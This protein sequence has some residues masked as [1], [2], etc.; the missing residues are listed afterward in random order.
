M[1]LPDLKEQRALRVAEMR[2]ILSAAETQKRSLTADEQGRFDKLKTE[3]TGL[4][5]D[6]ARAQFL[7]DAERR[8]MGGTD[9]HATE[10]ESRISLTDAIN[11]QVEGRALNGALAEY[12]QE[13]KRIGIVGRGVLVPQ[14]LF[15]KR[16]QTTGNS[17][18]IVPDDFLATEY[19]GLMR[20]SMVIQ[21]LGARVLPNLR[22]DTVIPKALTAHTAQWIG[23]GEALTPAD[24]TFG[25][26]TLTPKHVGALTSVSRQLLQQSNPAVEALIRDDFV[27]VVSLAVDKALIDGD[28]VNEPMGILERTG[29]GHAVQT[30]S[31]STVNWDA[32]L[33]VLEKLALVNASPNAWVTHPSV[34]TVLRG[35]LKDTGLPGYLMENGQL[36][37][38]PVAVTNQISAAA[39]NDG[40]MI[41]GDFSQIVIGQWGSVDILANPYETTAY[42]KGEV[43]IRILS[44]MDMN[45][46]NENAFVLIED[47]TI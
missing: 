18:S 5:A 6:E 28:G 47:V 9:K 44:T 45:V 33:T 21:K 25:S 7:E 16:V 10:L 24:A 20:N 30:G 26:I 29:V 43:L 36:A 35:T 12:Q 8:A 14:S 40:R 31:L 1:K 13:Q 42:T 34:A 15:E 11:A 27:Q 37:G 38:L 22:G 3:V 2:G 41:V 39:A 19:I 46:R 4:E 23:Q 17:G 32:V